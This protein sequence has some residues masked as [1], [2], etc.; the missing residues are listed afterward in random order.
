M[1]GRVLPDGFTVALVAT[2]GLASLFPAR[3]GGALAV[4]DASVLAIGLLFFLHG[5]RLPREAVLAGLGH[6]RLHLLVLAATFVLFPALALMGQAL[7]PGVL[8][9]RLW[10]GVLFA[11]ALPSTVQSSIAFTAMAR[12]N[13]PAAVCAATA[14]NL[15]GIFVTPVLVGLMLRL[16]GGGFSLDAIGKIVA[17]LLLPFLAGHL[18]RPWIGG[19]AGRHRR[20]LSF[21][22]RGSILLVVYGAF[23]E[24]V[25]EG[26]WR[27]VPPSQLLALAAVNAAL[28]GMVLLITGLGARALGFPREDE[29]TILFCG[30]KKSL[31]SG[32]P[33]ANVL[34][35]GPAVGISLLP[36]MLFHQMQLIVCAWLARAFAQ[37]AAAPAPGRPAPTEAGD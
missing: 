22:D 16:H 10:L 34:F 3:G 7:A 14:S 18:A 9:E 21:V 33:M 11:S 4:A 32:V 36:I 24:A 31:A 8:D 17:Q 29:I 35:A 25:T 30:S 13:V 2:V 19:F 28:L 23:G 6:W 5:A 15:L 20:L 27:L 26:L 12:G 37:R 1:I